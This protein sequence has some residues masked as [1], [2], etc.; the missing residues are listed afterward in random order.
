MLVEILNPVIL[1]YILLEI[2]FT[3]I[4]KQPMTY[5]QTQRMRGA[6]PPLP[7]TH[8]WRGAQLKKAQGQLYLYLLSSEYRGLF[9]GGKAAAA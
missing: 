3:H 4:L 1:S 7:N 9:P 5:V 8:S 2:N 6:I